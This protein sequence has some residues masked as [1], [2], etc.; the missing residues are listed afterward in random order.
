MSEVN[1]SLAITTYNRAD[2]LIPFVE[3]YQTY[4]YLDEIIILDD[5]SEDYQIFNKINWSD[6]VKIEQNL[7]NL[8]AYRNKLRVLSKTKND[9]VILFDSDNFF[10]QTFLDVLQDEK[11]RNG[12]SE[13]IIYC[14]SKA[15]PFDYSNLADILIDKTLWNQLHAKEA[16]FVNTGNMCLSRKAIDFLLFNFSIDEIKEPF[17]E[18][19][20]MNYLFIKNGFKLKAVKGLEYQHAISHDSFYISHQSQHVYFDSTFNWIIQ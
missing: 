16:C 5:C 11:S 4:K 1:F 19:K 12:L 14:P 9:W 13:D 3:K 6:K 8:G 7:V 17:V 18:C 20:Y 15:T 10:E 2:R